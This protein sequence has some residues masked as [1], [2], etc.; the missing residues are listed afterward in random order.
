MSGSVD[1][2][3]NG[4]WIGKVQGFKVKLGSEKQFLKARPIRIGQNG[5][6]GF[7][8]GRVDFTNKGF[9]LNRL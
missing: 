7:V 4:N 9:W 8:M 6:I 1:K 3:F 5:E 2:L